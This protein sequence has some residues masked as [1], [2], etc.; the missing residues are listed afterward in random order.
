MIQSEKEK[1]NGMSLEIE[2]SN[3]ELA[4]KLKIQEEKSIKLEKIQKIIEKI[5]RI[6]ESTYFNS[7][8]SNLRK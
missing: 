4:L 7:T 5:D 1:I 3:K 8:L 2:N 6:K